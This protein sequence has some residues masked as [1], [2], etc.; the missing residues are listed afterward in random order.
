M[1]GFLEGRQV[2]IPHDN[3]PSALP[4]QYFPAAQSQLLLSTHQLL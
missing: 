3:Q 2:G 4:L 1:R